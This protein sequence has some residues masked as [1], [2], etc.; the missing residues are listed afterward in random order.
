MYFLG[1]IIVAILIVFYIYSIQYAK[2]E[3][4]TVFILDMLKKVKTGDLIVFKSSNNFNAI[5]IGCYFTHIGMVYIKDNIP[6]IFEA[7]GLRGGAYTIPHHNPHGISISLLEERIKKYKGKCYLKAL[8]KPVDQNAI[9]NLEV[10][11]KFAVENMF[12]DYDV[13]KAGVRKLTGDKKCSYGTNCG[14]IMFLSLIKMGLLDIKLYDD[15]IA[16]HLKWV[17]KLEKLLKGYKYKELVEIIDTQYKSDERN[18]MVVIGEGK[19]VIE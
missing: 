2:L 8:N 13:L 10:F 5:Y 19:A 9:I 15:N 3:C 14:D 6:Y 18:D 17:I 4:D 7:N 12:Y 11:M 16:H 1:F